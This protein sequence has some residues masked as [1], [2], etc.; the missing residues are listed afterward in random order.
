MARAGSRESTT[1]FSTS[2]TP[3]LANL[4]ATSSTSATI[5]RALYSHRYGSSIG[6]TRHS[7]RSA[8]ALRAGAAIGAA[9][10]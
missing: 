8:D 10:E 5:T 9:P 3:T 1:S 7:R 2:G 6:T 4:A